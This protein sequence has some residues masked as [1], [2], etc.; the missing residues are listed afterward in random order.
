VPSAFALEQNYPNPFNPQ[1]TIRYHL[2]LQGHVTLTIYDMTGAVVT[3]LV[4]GEQAAGSYSQIWNAA[5]S[6][7]GL[8]FCELRTAS[9]REMRR[10]LL[11]K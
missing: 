6:P 7:S 1:T 3:R 11:V 9:S 4:D 8:Y 2:P 5:A 10:M